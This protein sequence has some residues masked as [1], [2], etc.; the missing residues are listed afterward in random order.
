MKD[1]GDF[2]PGGPR[3]IRRHTPA[4]N[5]VTSEPI[6]VLLVDDQPLF[7]CAIATLLDQQTDMR[8]VGEAGNGLEALDL[9]F[10]LRPDVV[11]MDVEMPVLDGVEAARR[12]REQLPHVK[13][14]MLTV[15]D[16]DE[17]LLTAIRL[18]VR[19]YLLKDLRPEELYEMIR[20]V[21]RDETPVSPSLVSRLV[22]EL[23]DPLPAHTPDAPAPEDSLSHRELEILQL[24]AR[25]LSNKEIGATLSITEGTVKNHVHN[26]LHKLQMEN[27][28]QA[29]AYIVRRGLARPEDPPSA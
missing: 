22:A 14:V 19:G 5:S 18:G 16:D 7:R 6:R 17:D 2:P 23:R 4:P 10:R 28:I 20:A 21:A 27:R 9:A 3:R 25:G 15:S 8:V 26:A 29:A 24:V 11:V 1:G 12:M 13:V